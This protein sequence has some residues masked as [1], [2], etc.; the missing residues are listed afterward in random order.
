MQLCSS[1]VSE[2]GI[3]AASKSLNSSNTSCI[4]ATSIVLFRSRQPARAGRESQADQLANTRGGVY[5]VL[6]RPEA[7]SLYNAGVRKREGI[8]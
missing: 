1:V 4:Q 7:T 2:K 8:V 3:C 5:N 6:F